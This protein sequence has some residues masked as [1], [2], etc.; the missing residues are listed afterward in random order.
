VNAAV[1]QPHCCNHSIHTHAAP[2]STSAKLQ[3]GALQA[4]T[5]LLI[6]EPRLMLLA[7]KHGIVSSTLSMSNKRDPLAVQQALKCWSDVLVSNAI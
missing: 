3:Q 6:G 1:Y 2:S 4:L 5:S 7:Q